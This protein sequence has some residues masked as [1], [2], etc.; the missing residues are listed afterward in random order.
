[1][2]QSFV[3][4]CYRCICFHLCGLMEIIFAPTMLTM[5]V[6]HKT[7]EWKLSLTNLVV[8]DTMIEI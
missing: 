7:V 1:M 5:G 4:F 6:L 2:T 3:N 8:L